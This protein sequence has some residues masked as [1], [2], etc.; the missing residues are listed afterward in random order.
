MTTCRYYNVASIRF[1]AGTINFSSPGSMVRRSR[2]TAFSWT[3]LKMG[4]SL[5]RSRAARSSA[6]MFPSGLSRTTNVLI[7]YPASEPPPIS[8]S[9]SCASAANRMSVLLA[10]GIGKPRD[11]Q[12]AERI[13]GLPNVEVIGV[14]RARHNVIDALMRQ[15]KFL[16]LLHR[17]LASPPAT[18]TAVGSPTSCGAT[19]LPTPLPSGL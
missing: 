17:L 7:G 2:R 9:D 11:R 1:S 14:D 12:Q 19:P 18:S 4:G 5:L 16:P 8:D 10:Y 13:G 3:R 15:Q 6:E